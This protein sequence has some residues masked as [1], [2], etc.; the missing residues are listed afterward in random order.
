VNGDVRAALEELEFSALVPAWNEVAWLPALINRLWSEP[1]VAEIVVADNFSEDGTVAA[2]LAGGSTVVAGGLPAV[3]RNAAAAVAHGDLLLFIDAD[4]AITPHV[5]AELHRQFSD[6]TRMLVYFRLVPV[7][8]RRFVKACYAMVD[9]Y[10]RICSAIGSPEGSAPLIC[11]RRSAFSAVGGFRE[12]IGVA[13]DADFIRRVG[14][15]VGGVA[16]VRNTILPVSARRF[17]LESPWSYCI[18]CITWGLLRLFRLRFSGV[19]YTWVRYPI[20]IAVADPVVPE[21]MVSPRSER[22]SDHRPPGGAR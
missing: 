17:S 16:Y 11:V 10:A 20:A 6:P 5:F 15:R 4:V 2:A 8:E 19:P 1:S 7:T 18:K 13:E 22:E 12:D 14:A 9:I 3:G 21:V